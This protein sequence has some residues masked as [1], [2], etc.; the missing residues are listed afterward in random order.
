MNEGHSA[1]LG[2]ER[3]LRLSRHFQSRPCSVAKNWTRKVS[4]SGGD[5]AV[6]QSGLYGYAI[7]V[8]PKH[9]DALTPFMPGLN[10]WARGRTARRTDK[11]GQGDLASE[12]LSGY[13]VS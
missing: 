2:L 9:S 4:L 5:S 12:F 1:F 6:A 10:L 11:P 3:M 8:L 7:R 13:G